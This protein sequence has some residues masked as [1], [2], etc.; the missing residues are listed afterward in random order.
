LISS[1]V[2]WAVR[3]VESQAPPGLLGAR[4]ARFAYRTYRA[5]YA[6]DQGVLYRVVPKS[7]FYN[8]L[9]YGEKRG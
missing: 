9:L 3:T 2:G 1:L 4:W 7:F 5:L 6:V 8:V